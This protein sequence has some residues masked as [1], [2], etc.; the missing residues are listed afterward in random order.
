MRFVSSDPN[1]VLATAGFTWS[2]LESLDLSVTG[3]L[4]F[5]AGSD[6]YGVLLGV[7]PKLRLFGGKGPSASEKPAP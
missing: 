7:S 3:L 1:Q 2:A 4:G 6:R 5:L